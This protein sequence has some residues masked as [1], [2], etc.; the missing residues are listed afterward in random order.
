VF[1]RLTDESRKTFEN[2]E[3]GRGWGGINATAKSATRINNYQ[4]WFKS[5]IHRTFPSLSSFRT[6]SDRKTSERYN[7]KSRLTTSTVVYV[8]GLRDG[9]PGVYRANGDSRYQETDLDLQTDH[10]FQLLFWFVRSSLYQSPCSVQ[11]LTYRIDKWRVMKPRGI[12]CRY[13]RQADTAL[14]AAKTPWIGR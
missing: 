10:V 3:L 8:P 2:N 1:F 13:G 9:I 6:N 7:T 14:S 5:M 11:E 12:S 4:A